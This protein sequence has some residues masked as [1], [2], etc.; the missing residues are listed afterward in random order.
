MRLSLNQDGRAAIASIHERC[1]K[2]NADL[3]PVISTF[4]Y[5]LLVALD[6]VMTKDQWTEVAGQLTSER[7]KR[8]RLM[9]RL[10]GIGDKI[11]EAD[12]EKL[13]RKVERR[14]VVSGSENSQ[15]SAENS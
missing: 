6:S 10:K 7:A 14:S 8:K 3:E 13:E 4:L 2:I 11:D 12:V 1:K 15:N 5:R 9:E